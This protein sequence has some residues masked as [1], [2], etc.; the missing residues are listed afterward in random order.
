MKMNMSGMLTVAAVVAALN[1]GANST[2]SGGKSSPATPLGMDTQRHEGRA[3]WL[4]AAGKDDG[5]ETLEPQPPARPTKGKPLE[6]VPGSK[7]ALKKARTI[8]VAPG[9]D[10]KQIGE[11]EE[12]LVIMSRLLSKELQNED[13][14]WANQAMGIFITSF[15]QESKPDA[16]YLEGSGAVFF[17]EVRFPL[18]PN[19]ELKPDKKVEDAKDSEWEKARQEVFGEGVAVA[20]NVK[21]SIMVDGHPFVPPPYDAARVE[22]LKDSLFSVLRNATNIRALKPEEYVTVAVTSIPMSTSFANVGVA[23]AAA[24]DGTP[25]VYKSGTTGRQSVMTIRVKKAD[26]DAFAQGKLSLEQFK[27]KASVRIY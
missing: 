6:K 1:V 19:A 20:G 4:M 21:T 13:F 5:W 9:A 27:N 3:E 7:M 22:R 14:K 10:A 15:G 2:V 25:K 16:L 12:D 24:G 23:V 26:V 11:I 8:V 17:Q 18:L